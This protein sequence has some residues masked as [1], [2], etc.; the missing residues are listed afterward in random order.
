MVEKRKEGEALADLEEESIDGCTPR[1]SW[2]D[3]GEMERGGASTLLQVRSLWSA[4]E[5]VGEWGVG[6]WGVGV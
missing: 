2:R 1:V 5:G 3:P 6:E 4:C